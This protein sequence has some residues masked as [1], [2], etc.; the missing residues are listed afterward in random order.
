[1]HSQP[2]LESSFSDV[3]AKAWLESVSLACWQIIKPVGCPWIWARSNSSSHFTYKFMAGGAEHAS[4]MQRGG[5]HL[6]G[7][8]VLGYL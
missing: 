7:Y 3:A 8:L 2:C 1:M 5:A 4:P 6:F